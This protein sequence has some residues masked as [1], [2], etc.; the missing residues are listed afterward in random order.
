MG[1]VSLSCMFMF[2]FSD[3]LDFW[4]FFSIQWIFGFS[5]PS[6]EREN[7]MVVLAKPNLSFPRSNSE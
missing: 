1:K 4:I 7:Q 6:I 5:G 3:P 2:Q